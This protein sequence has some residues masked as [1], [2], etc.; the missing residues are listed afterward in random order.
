M[1]LYTADTHALVW[2]LQQAPGRQ[3]SKRRSG[4]SV[5]ARRVFTAADEGRETVLI[6]SIVLVEIIYL[7]ERDIVPQTLVNDLLSGIRQGPE[8]YRII[9]LDL[10]IIRHLR[11]IPSTAVP[12]MP[13]RIIAAT[14]RATRSRLLS[15]DSAMTR[16]GIDVVW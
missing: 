15:K 16:A 13:D 5:R 7:G 1:G 6:P 4:L 3:P 11:E 8:N 14:A 2:H 12:E 10:N 9:P